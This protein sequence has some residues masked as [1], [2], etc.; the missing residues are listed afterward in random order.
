MRFPLLPCLLLP[1]ACGG[2]EAYTR[3]SERA[4]APEG[5]P[6]A[7]A[8]ASIRFEPYRYGAHASM[9]EHVVLSLALEGKEKPL[10]LDDAY[11]GDEPGDTPADEYAQLLEPA[12]ELRFAPDGHALAV[13]IDGGK[14]FRLVVFDLGEPM[15][16]RHERLAAARLWGDVPSSRRLALDIL[17]SADPPVGAQTLHLE[18]GEYPRARERFGRELAVAR[19]FA[20]AHPD[21]A[22]LRDAVVAALVR[23]GSQI[24]AT[25]EYMPL[26]ECVSALARDHVELRAPLVAALTS[27]PL[28]QRTRAALALGRSASAEVERAL[29]AAAPP[30]PDEC[31]PTGAAKSEPRCSDTRFTR[32]A[33]AW[34]LAA[35]STE[36]AT[37]SPA[38]LAFAHSL[39]REDDDRSKVLAIRLLALSGDPAARAR[40][41]ELAAGPCETPQ[42]WRDSSGDLFEDPTKVGAPA[43]WAKA[44]LAR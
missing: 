11:R 37:I 33:I 38:A 19:G 35:V 24:F 5:A 28:E 17:A 36:L 22:E 1:L 21:D 7:A 6:F 44:A 15:F 43:C 40:I 9:S 13:S 20:C 29:A 23:P 39:S 27:A 8:Q 18:P 34:S 26:V 31:G 32:V 3:E 16:C 10:E 42:P 4:A 30:M 2:K 25:S 12:F 14:L 41:T